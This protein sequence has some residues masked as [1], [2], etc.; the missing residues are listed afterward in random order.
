MIR[1]RFGFMHW[2][3]GLRRCF[4]KLSMSGVLVEFKDQARSS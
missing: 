2:N 3:L 1:S 4:D